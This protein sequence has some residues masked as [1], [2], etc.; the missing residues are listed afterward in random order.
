MPQLG[1]LVFPKQPREHTTA[2][3]LIIRG[4][5]GVTGKASTVDHSMVNAV[6]FRSVSRLYLGY[7]TSR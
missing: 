7:M 3:V 4:E 6:F 1:Q 5:S 2:Q